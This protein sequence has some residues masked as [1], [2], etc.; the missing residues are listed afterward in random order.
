MRSPG[1]GRFTGSAQGFSG[2]TPSKSA[3]ILPLRFMT[4]RIRIRPAPSFRRVDHCT[5]WNGS[6]GD[7]ADR[8]TFRPAA[9]DQVSPARVFVRE[10]GV[11]LSG[12]ELVN[13][14]GLL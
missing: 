11:E 6:P 7:A 8:D 5:H 4:A 9:G 12:S 3:S 10:H 2:N 13:R 1:P 14:L